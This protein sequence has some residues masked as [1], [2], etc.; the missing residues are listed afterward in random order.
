LFIKFYIKMHIYWYVNFCGT[1]LCKIAGYESVR[2]DSW[3]I[4]F[5]MQNETKFSEFGWGE[6]SA[7]MRFVHCGSDF[8]YGEIVWSTVLWWIQQ[9][10]AATI[11][12]LQQLFGCRWVDKFK[13]YTFMHGVSGKLWILMGALVNIKKLTFLNSL[14]W[15]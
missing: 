3:S 5:N 14:F 2:L 7:L 8:F 4:R 12:T 6:P 9:G 13:G 1:Y 11:N 10:I 15:W